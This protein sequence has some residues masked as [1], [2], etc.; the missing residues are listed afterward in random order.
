MSSAE[1]Q[2][3]TYLT[4]SLFPKHLQ[5]TESSHEN[6]H[7]PSYFRV[8]AQNLPR[9]ISEVLGPTESPVVAVDAH[10]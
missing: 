3:I 2:T 6:L 8:Y 1:C 4:T 5:T 10:I 7:M 9:L